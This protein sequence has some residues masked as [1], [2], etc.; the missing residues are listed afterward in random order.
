M[1]ALR[2]LSMRRQDILPVQV[3]VLLL[4]V[5]LDHLLL[6]CLGGGRL[7][8]LLR[9]DWQLVL[10]LVSRHRLLEELLRLL[11]R[12]ADGSLRLCFGWLPGDLEGRDR[13]VSIRLADFLRLNRARRLNGTLGMHAGLD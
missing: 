2:R 8:G 13:I 7:L 3:R 9:V 6:H 10:R 4:A 11:A 1:G 5:A 12:I